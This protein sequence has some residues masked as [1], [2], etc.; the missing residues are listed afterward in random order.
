MTYPGPE[1]TSTNNMQNLGQR[2]FPAISN[3]CS[4]TQAVI[5]FRKEKE[6]LL[7]M[8]TK[9]PDSTTAPVMTVVGA[10]ESL[11]DGKDRQW[12]LQSAASKFNVTI[13]TPNTDGQG[14]SRAAAGGRCVGARRSITAAQLIK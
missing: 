6:A 2:G 4:L 1:K 14:D 5:P 8:A 3:Y 9:K 11:R 13:S 12:V 7:L 10:L